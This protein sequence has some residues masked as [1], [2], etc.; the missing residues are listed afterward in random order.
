MKALPHESCASSRE[1]APS[2]DEPIGAVSLLQHRRSPEA[3]TAPTTAAAAAA[4]TARGLEQLEHRRT[5][6]SVELQRLT[7][8]TVKAERSAAIDSADGALAEPPLASTASGLLLPGARTLDGG[9]LFE[10]AEAA[11][12]APSELLRE[13]AHLRGCRWGTL[14]H[15]HVSIFT[16]LV[17]FATVLCFAFCM[18]EHPPEA[19]DAGV[20]ASTS[21]SAQGCILASGWLH[22]SERELPESIYGAAIAV[23][24]VMQGRHTKSLTAVTIIVHLYLA[25]CVLVQLYIVYN[26]KAYMMVPAREHLRKIYHEF[27]NVTTLEGE[28]SQSL[29]EGWAAVETKR[30]LCE[31]PLA[32]PRFFLTII[33]TWTLCVLS[34]LRETARYAWLWLRL[35]SEAPERGAYHE[36]NGKMVAESASAVLKARVLGFVL[37]PKGFIAVC[38]WYWGANWLLSTTRFQDIVLNAVAL[39]FVVD[40]DDVFFK[41]LLPGRVQALT[42]SV[43]LQ[44]KSAL[45]DAASAASGRQRHHVLRTM[46]F[47]ASAAC[48]TPW[49]YLK[50][51]SVLPGYHFELVQ[52]CRLWRASRE[53]AWLSLLSG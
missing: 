48:V 9:L 8:A 24:V 22:A 49:V 21:S 36:E 17:I 51:Q 27:Q 18:I 44:A 4:A 33:F 13:A 37:L 12:A 42:R 6:L 47:L 23:T 50:T 26:I 41:V 16:A 52:P 2:S 25:L 35:D 10:P 46:A 7:S 28:F 38:L 5:S 1:Q 19:V 11:S 15:L 40:L 39:A 53:Q 29:W 20:S 34:D 45:G 14:T 43:R 32:A 31:V 3:G 30:E